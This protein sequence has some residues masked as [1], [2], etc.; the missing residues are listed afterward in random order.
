[1]KG[2]KALHW[3]GGKSV[4]KKYI[5]L[6]VVPTDPFY[7]MAHP[8]PNKEHRY[9]LEHR[10]IMAHYL[11]RCLSPDEVVHHINGDTKDNRISNLEL[12]NR[13]LHHKVHHQLKHKPNGQFA[14]S[15]MEHI[16]E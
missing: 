9:I 2:N 8:L 7:S 15:T 12:T 4:S 5:I 10:L 13:V 6:Y 11:G 1:M 14:K 16:Q 3:K